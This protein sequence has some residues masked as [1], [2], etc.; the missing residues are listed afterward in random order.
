VDQ[1][2][3]LPQGQGVAQCLVRVCYAPVTLVECHT[4]PGQGRQGGYG[5]LFIH[6]GGNLVGPSLH[7]ILR[8]MARSS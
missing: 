2:A 4:H 7:N 3:P 8:G 1:V 6:L 5:M